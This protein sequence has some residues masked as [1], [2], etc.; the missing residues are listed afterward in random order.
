MNEYNAGGED[1]EVLQGFFPKNWRELARS[2]GAL[3][4]LRKDKSPDNLLRTILLHVGCGHSLRE[5]VT[6]ARQAGL[7][8][9]SDVA[10][11]KRLRKCE[12]WL[13]A[14]S[15]ELWER[16]GLAPLR[17]EGRAMRVVDATTVKEPG[18]TGSLWRIH[19]SMRLP[20]LRCDYFKVSATEGA[21][22]AEG[23][24]QIPAAEGD[25][26]MGDR[27]YSNARGIV[28]AALA[29][30]FLLVRLNSG[31]TRPLDRRG[32]PVNLLAKFGKL[33]SA[34]DVGSWDAALEY[35]GSRLD[36]RICAARKSRAAIE[37]AHLAL[38]RKASK[39][40]TEL[41]PETLEHAKYV[42]V[43][44]SFP[45]EEF[46]AREIMEC[47]RT[48]WQVELVFK[49]FKQIAGLG[50]LPKHDDASARAW[51]YGKLTVALLTEDLLAHAGAFSPWGYEFDSAMHPQSMA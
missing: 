8:D 49:R 20:S 50:H 26:I 43:L 7:A 17:T 12:G 33:T 45:A 4:G 23:L 51:L 22:T 30:A 28:S 47:Y 36:V 2:T 13:H 24:W 21:G 25:Y 41:K 39:Q 15:A 18:K 40:M 34:G 19:Y 32:R 29:G 44:T 16:R 6:R 3:K 5:T 27:G 46:S 9:L 37:T 10:F 38:R 31:S 48:R 14:L 11:L 35:E 42:A 1:W